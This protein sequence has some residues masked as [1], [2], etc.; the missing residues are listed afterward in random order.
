MIFIIFYIK[1]YIHFLSQE[2]LFK[3]LLL[4]QSLDYNPGFF[5]VKKP[6]DVAKPAG[7]V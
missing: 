3:T 7:L 6:A 1:I 5:S 4:L 2:N